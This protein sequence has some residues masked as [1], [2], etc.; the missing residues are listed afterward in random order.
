[1][2]LEVPEAD[3]DVQGASS[4]YLDMQEAS[5]QCISRGAGGKQ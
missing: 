4:W 5:L 3:L 2:Y 1:M